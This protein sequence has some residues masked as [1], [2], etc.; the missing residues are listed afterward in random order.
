MA[1]AQEFY[2][3][4]RRDKMLRAQEEDHPTGSRPYRKGANASRM[5]DARASIKR[6]RQSHALQSARI[7]QWKASKE[8]QSWKKRFGQ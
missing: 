5:E 1:T 3:L 8:A 7:R 4:W 6:H 2:D